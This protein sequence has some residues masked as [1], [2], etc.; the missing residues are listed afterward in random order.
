MSTETKPRP[1]VRQ[2]TFLTKRRLPT[3]Q[4]DPTLVQWVSPATCY[5]HTAR[6]GKAVAGPTR[7]PTAGL[8][9]SRFFYV[10][11][12]RQT[13]RLEGETDMPTHKGTGGEKTLA[14]AVKNTG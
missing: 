2:P 5:I 3:K 12:G 7:L 14:M 6:L 4:T 11:G 9:L 1:I 10:R 8:K 13:H